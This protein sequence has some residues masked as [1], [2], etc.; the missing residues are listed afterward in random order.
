MDVRLTSNP[1]NREIGFRELFIEAWISRWAVLSITMAFAVVG[2]VAGFLIPKQ[3]RAEIL[4]TPTDSPTGSSGGLGS[5]ASQ[6][7]AL[8]SLA[9]ISVSGKNSKAEAIAVLQSELITEAYVRDNN[10][11]PVLYFNSWDQGSGTWKSTDPQKIPTLWKANRYFK[12]IREV[13]E[14]R[15]TGL[16]TMRITWRDAAQAAKWANDLVRITNKYLRD[17][18]IKESEENIAYLNEQ[19]LKTNVIEVKTAIYSLLKEEVNKQMIARGRE[20][21]A[22]KVLDP[23]RPPEVRSS[24]SVVFLGAAG[25]AA[26]LVISMLF[27]WRRSSIE[28]RRL[29]SDIRGADLP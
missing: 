12:S 28:E 20:E 2:I 13:K 7:G 1:A 17:K 27:I 11:L 3:Y 26:G 9:G 6:Y 14:D 8:A 16:V 18:A 22:L 23:A 15:Q 29:G 19:A 24:P 21:Y 10:L 4:I 25:F 5:I